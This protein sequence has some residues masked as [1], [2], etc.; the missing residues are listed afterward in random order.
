MTEEE[1]DTVMQDNLK[2]MMLCCKYSIPQMRRSGGGSIINV[3]SGAGLIGLRDPN[4]EFVAYSTAKAGVSGL[5]RALAAELAA[6]GIRVNCIVVGMVD[7]P[8]VE[9]LEEEVREKRRLAVPLQTTGTG[10]GL[11]P[12]SSRLTPGSWGFWSDLVKTGG[13]TINANESMSLR[14]SVSHPVASIY[15]SDR[16]GRPRQ[17]ASV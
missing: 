16:L 15:S 10:C 1:W 8:V 11:R 9:H 14:R 7:T 17:R 5:T 13:T 6:D 4:Q 3:S 12:L 2:S